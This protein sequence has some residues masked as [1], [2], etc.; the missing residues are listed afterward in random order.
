MQVQKLSKKQPKTINRI[1]DVAGKFFSKN[2]YLGVSMTDVARECGISK[3]AI[4]HYFISK[5]ELYLRLIENAA[6]TLEKEIE[7]IL[8]KKTSPIS[9]LVNLIT[10]YLKFGLEKKDIINLV[11][12]GESQLD[13]EIIDFLTKFRQRILNKI[14]SL[15]KQ[16]DTKQNDL[17]LKVTLL[18][19]M[20]NSFII[21]QSFNKN[22]K[23]ISTKKIAK[24]A[25]NLFIK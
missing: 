4:Y 24:E 9:K 10:A 12:Q 14:V 15:F 20:M 22:H 3:P 1:L 23:K 8:K 21:S 6:S 13:Q 17:V 5:K 19:G 18:I 25:I 16:I 7:K 2:G 11:F